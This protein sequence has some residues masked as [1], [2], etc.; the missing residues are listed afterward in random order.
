MAQTATTSELAK[1]ADRLTISCCVLLD[2]LFLSRAA[3]N[4]TKA[5]NGS[6]V[7]VNT[8]FPQLQG[9]VAAGAGLMDAMRRVV[10]GACALA[11][12]AAVGLFMA[13][14]AFEHRCRK[15]RFVECSCLDG[16]GVD[17]SESIDSYVS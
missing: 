13:A 16:H 3:A 12:L 11:L 10:V 17:L 2:A 1:W 8:I 5:P 7:D 14:K 6:R 15:K 4:K 9:E